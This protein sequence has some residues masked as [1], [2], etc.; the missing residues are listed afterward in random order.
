MTRCERSIADPA[1]TVVTSVAQLQQLI[2]GAQRGEQIRARGAMHSVC[3]AILTD[4]G[5]TAGHDVY[6]AGDLATVAMH[7]TLRDVVRAGAGA[8]LGADPDEG[9]GEEASFLY[10]LSHHDPPW[11]VPDLGGIVHQSVGGFLSTGSSGGSLRYSFEQA[12]VGFSFVD[13]TGEVHQVSR[14]DPLFAAIGVSMGLLGIITSVDIQPVPRFAVK[15]Q[16]STTDIDKAAYSLFAPGKGGLEAFLRA[17]DYCRIMWWP[18]RDVNKLVTWT[19]QRIDIPPNFV[20]VPYRELGDSDENPRAYPRELPI[21]LGRLA[22]ALYLNRGDIRAL[23]E[24]HEADLP[25]VMTEFV[26]KVLAAVEAGDFERVTQII[27][28]AT[29]EEIQEVGVDLYFSLLGNRVSNEL[30]RRLFTATFGSESEWEA[31]WSP[32]INNGIFLIDDADKVVPGPQ[33]FEDYAESGL[34]MDD[35]ISDLLMPTEFTE[36]W[37]PIEQ[38]APTM[39]LLAQHYATGY[40]ATGT[41]ACELYAAMSSDFLMS[42]ASGQEV[43]RVDLFWFGRNGDMTAP[44]FYEQFWTLLAKNGISFRPHWGK[45]LPPAS[46]FGPAYYR[47]V[48][49]ENLAQFL[50]L[51]AQLDPNQLFVTHYWREQLGIPPP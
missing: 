43:I 49:G 37:I 33:R 6:L 7:P 4:P 25:P 50:E 39:K 13:G 5:A 42:P 11:S 20:P 24:A 31:K 51:R 10:W 46:T 21:L 44:Q 12:I 34:P 16:E 23:F 26:G 2:R 35:Q 30:A 1:Y 18:Q 14:G 29:N 8:R 28:D 38:T 27:E 45:Y 3:D 41:Y 32:L 40:A 19:A 15:G 17:N 36:L 9:V 48:Y 22:A 47:S